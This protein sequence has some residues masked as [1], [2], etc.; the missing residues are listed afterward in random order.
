M[1]G[2]LTVLPWVQKNMSYNYRFYASKMEELRVR[3]EANRPLSH[4][5]HELFLFVKECEAR[6]GRSSAQAS[7]E[8]GDA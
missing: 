7:E 4:Q 3:R 1:G 8:S 6:W 5:L 2:A